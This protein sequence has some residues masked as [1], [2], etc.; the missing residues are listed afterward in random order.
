MS[1]DRLHVVFQPRGV[2]CV[3][4]LEIAKLNNKQYT[5]KSYQ[6]TMDLS[7]ELQLDTNVF[8]NE[9]SSD[10]GE[11]PSCI[12]FPTI[13]EEEQKIKGDLKV[14]PP[15][16]HRKAHQTPP[17]SLGLMSDKIV[18]K[19]TRSQ[20][21]EGQT[22]CLMSPTYYPSILE[23]GSRN[24]SFAPLSTFSKPRGHSRSKSESLKVDTV[25][26]AQNIN[27]QNPF[28]IREN[29]LDITQETL[30]PSSPNLESRRKQSST[31]SSKTL[32]SQSCIHSPL[33][34]SY[35]NHSK[36]D[37]ETLYCTL[38]RL[39]ISEKGVIT[40]NA[41]KKHQVQDAIHP[42]SIN[43]ENIDD[44]TK[45]ANAAEK[46][47]ISLS[48]KLQYNDIIKELNT[49][50]TRIGR[51][52]PEI[53][54]VEEECTV[55]D[56]LAQEKAI[57][58]KVV[59]K[60]AFSLD[61]P[62]L[63]SKMSRSNYSQKKNLKYREKLSSHL[64]HSTTKPNNQICNSS[65]IIHDE[66]GSILENKPLLSHLTLVVANEAVRVFQKDLPMEPDI[67][68]NLKLSHS[69]Q[70]ELPINDGTEMSPSWYCDDDGQEFKNFQDADK[71][72]L[73]V[74]TAYVMCSSISLLLCSNI[75]YLLS[76]LLDFIFN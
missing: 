29:A 8:S 72:V 4:E 9:I 45:L 34:N 7:K 25:A 66:D 26:P 16:P 60:G 3:S 13:D 44:D 42:S 37:T 35:A 46:E 39:V 43:P 22:K 58:S 67:H 54:D 56:T 18:V 11:D 59:D 76:C 38:P 52:S 55:T 63:L 61:T 68:P 74:T 17:M 53:I 49:H 64:Q 15:K 33:G 71:V 51:S 5:R 21:M 27:K 57:D 1:D 19:P 10:S 62:F 47:G 40:G 6:S 20:H 65:F 12:A 28:S 50:T 2:S 32:L 14:P 24:S 41:P 70:D 75:Y 48:A 73:I 69:N 31:P 23:A 36:E 30:S